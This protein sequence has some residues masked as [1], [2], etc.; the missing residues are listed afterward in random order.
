[1]QTALTND[2]YDALRQISAGPHG[3]RP[4]ACVARNV[5]RLAGLK[6]V[7]YRKDGSLALT[8]KA[9]EAMFLR[10]CVEGM[11]AVASDPLV[12]LANDVHTFLA[13]K[14]HIAPCATGGVELTQRGR[15]SLEDIDLAAR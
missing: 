6:F 9:T 15:E 8:E 3:D 1:M 13:K 2:E 7:S 10:G 11:R 5:K 12:T 4:S 14:G